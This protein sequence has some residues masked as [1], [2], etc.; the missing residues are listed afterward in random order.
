MV[1][2]KAEIS[3]TNG[4]LNNMVELLKT[5]VFPIMEGFGWRMIGCFVQTSGRLGTIVDLWEMNDLNVFSGVYD[6]YRSHPDYPEIR[7]LLDIYI[8]TETIVFMEAKAGRLAKQ[9]Q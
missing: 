6:R 1:Y 3:V 8:D 7:R 4:N 2:M 5:R 9:E